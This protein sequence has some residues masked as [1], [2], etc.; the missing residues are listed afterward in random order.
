MTG[1][2]S[3]DPWRS[4]WRPE[5]I[6][7]VNPYHWHSTV[8]LPVSWIQREGKGVEKRRCLYFERPKGGSIEE[9]RTKKSP[10][11]RLHRPD[12]V[13]LESLCFSR[14]HRPGRVG[15]QERT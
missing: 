5:G 2:L 4:N 6:R 1:T 11:S 10:M 7:T 13:V 12:T 15:T 9:T 3:G 14:R 8:D